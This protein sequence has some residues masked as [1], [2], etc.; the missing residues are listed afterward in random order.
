MSMNPIA[1]KLPNAFIPEERVNLALSSKIDAIYKHE[2]IIWKVRVG[3]LAILYTGLTFLLGQRN[4]LADLTTMDSAAWLI[5]FFLIL[6]FSLSA[7][8]VDLAYLRK[9]LRIIVIRDMLI[10]AAYNPRCRLRNKDLY[11][12][13]Q[14][15]SERPLEEHFP[16]GDKKLR[17]KLNWNIKRI[18]LPIYAAT[19]LLAF[20]LFLSVY[21]H[22]LFVWLVSRG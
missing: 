16:E 1:P 9:R 5:I 18:L 6:G 11:M 2:E 20:V 15:G 8:M 17:L 21:L 14:I 7:F 3:Y 22:R 13:L 12:L 10:D 19:P 4:V